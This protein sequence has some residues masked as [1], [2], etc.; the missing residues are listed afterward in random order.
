MNDLGRCLFSRTFAAERKQHWHSLGHRCD[1]PTTGVA[2]S[3]SRRRRKKC[4]MCDGCDV[5]GQFNQPFSVSSHD[6]QGFKHIL[7][8]CRPD[9]TSINCL[10]M[11][12]NP[13]C[14]VGWDP[15]Q[16]Q[17]PPEFLPHAE[18][19]VSSNRNPVF[20]LKKACRGVGVAYS[21]GFYDFYGLSRFNIS[22]KRNQYKLPRPIIL[23]LQ[24]IASKSVNWV[25][26]VAAT[27]FVTFKYE[28]CRFVEHRSWSKKAMT[29]ARISW[30]PE[31]SLFFFPRLD[32]KGRN[33]TQG[34]DIVNSEK[35]FGKSVF[36]HCMTLHGWTGNFLIC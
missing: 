27:A 2:K 29:Y 14:M 17:W 10:S 16:Q 23:Q 11:S 1:M 26:R 3:I 31:G 33:C 8:V 9:W 15:S 7:P 32:Q 21:Y 25:S 35:W 36:K 22:L 18:V 28:P 4:T 6:L 5:D 20:L 34:G 30:D 13:L 24:K 19:L 12:V